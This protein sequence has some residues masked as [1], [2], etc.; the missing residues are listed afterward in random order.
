MSRTAH[1]PGAFTL[2]ELLVVIGIIALL[3]SILLPSLAK[4]REAAIR[5]SCGSRLRQIGQAMIMYGN[6]NRGFMPAALGAE[7]NVALRD[8]FAE[9]LGLLLSPQDSR[10]QGWA[11]SQSQSTGYLPD[12]ILRC[13]GKGYEGWT[14]WN[15]IEDTGYAYNVPGS[16]QWASR[17]RWVAWRPNQVLADPLT[18]N[19]VPD[20][21]Y[22]PGIRYR[23]MVA[24]FVETLGSG[25]D[26]SPGNNVPNW[27]A[28]RP[29]R[30]AGVNLLC[31]DGSVRW[32]QRPQ[33]GWT[34]QPFW[35]ALDWGNVY[36][37]GGN[38]G[39][40]DPTDHGWWQN[41]NDERG[42]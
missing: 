21:S 10:W 35:W 36:D 32:V 28:N 8:P 27:L 39:V 25:N 42:L 18:G 15:S 20:W 6:D 22:T 34:N 9:R 19:G 3:I 1:R 4:A 14:N 11:A 2:V 13:P 33:N 41:M 38:G 7:S 37:W 5:I 29:H 12:Q 24:C 30:N 23:A 40:P 17:Q 16:V 26:Y 31:F